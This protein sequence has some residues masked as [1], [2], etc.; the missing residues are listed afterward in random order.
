MSG[1]Y[2]VISEQDAIVKGCGR[3]CSDMLPTTLPTI[4]VAPPISL[5]AMMRENPEMEIEKDWL[6][7]MAADKTVH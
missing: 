1:F 3:A 2:Q 7:A 5:L 4:P 6:A